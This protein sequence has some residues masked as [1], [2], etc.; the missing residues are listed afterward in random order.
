MFKISQG[1]ADLQNHYM[2]LEIDRIHNA[3]LDTLNFVSLSKICYLYSLRKNFC[4]PI[5]VALIGRNLNIHPGKKRALIAYLTGERYIPSIFVIA[6]ANEYLNQ[7]PFIQDAQPFDN[8]IL[9]NL[10]DSNIWTINVEGQKQYAGEENENR[11][12]CQ[13]QGYF[14]EN[15]I[16]VYGNIVIKSK[17][18]YSFRTEYNTTQKTVI[19]VQ[20]KKQAFKELFKI[21][22]K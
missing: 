22:D 19:K 17:C 8:P 6:T 20:N 18:G 10:Y 12:N 16:D 4:N 13:A 2:K 5:T 15:I 11:Y 9:T 1:N 21:I 14:Q 3:V 7:I